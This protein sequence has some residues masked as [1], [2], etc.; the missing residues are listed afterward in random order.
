VNVSQALRLGLRGLAGGDTLPRLLARER[1]KRHLHGQPRLTEDQI[2]AWAQAHHS[3]TGRWP[4]ASSGPVEGAPGETWPAVRE[5]L[6][7]GLRGLP[8]GSLARLLARRLGARNRGDLPRLSE[9]L[10][11]R[12]ADAH[13][14]AHGRWPSANSGP[15]DTAPGETWRAVESALRQGCRGLPGGSS[16]AC[17]LAER[18][19][20][21]NPK[22]L[23]RLTEARILAWADAHRRRTGE[24]PTVRSGPVAG[25]PGETW[26]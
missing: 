17:L 11:L 26:Y 8:R 19:Q 20:V 22:R 3:R 9:R 1:G 4:N 7:Q 24:W 15:V 2:V 16:L 10:I 13:R 23:P 18:R 14:R 5:A 21:P 12:W 6:K 25:E